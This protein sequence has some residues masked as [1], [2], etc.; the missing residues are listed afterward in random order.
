[1]IIGI[2]Q[3]H[4]II[5]RASGTAESMVTVDDVTY[6]RVD[7]IPTVGANETLLFHPEEKA[8]YRVERAP[9]DAESAE[10]AKARV[11]AY[12]AS[13]KTQEAV[14]KWL[15]END[16][17]VNKHALGEWTD[18]DPRWLAYLTERAEKRAAYEQAE[19]ALQASA[20]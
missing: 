7:S 17:K 10:A 2:N 1:M 9:M 16:W 4:E 15:S 3:T 8:F 14:L 5:F 11:Q 12:A 20:G 13:K 6:F 18:D 19:Q